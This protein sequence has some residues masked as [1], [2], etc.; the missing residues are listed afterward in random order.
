MCAQVPAA[1]VGHE[2]IGD[3]IGLIAGENVVAG[4]DAFELPQVGTVHDRDQFG[5]GHAAQSSIEG[6]IRVEVGEPGCGKDRG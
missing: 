4:D 2:L 3:G 1:S 5:L 6:E